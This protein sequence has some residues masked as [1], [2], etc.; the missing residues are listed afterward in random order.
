MEKTRSQKQMEYARRT[1]FAASK[2]YN[3]EKTKL[4]R[5]C[6]SKS[7]QS[8]MIEWLESKSNKSGYIKQLILSDIREKTDGKV[9]L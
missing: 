3:K 5:I 8:D 9:E 6:F 7:N 4:V 2:K 1:G